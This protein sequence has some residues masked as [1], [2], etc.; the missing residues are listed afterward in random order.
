MLFLAVLV[1][2][3]AVVFA[4]H[5]DGAT[6]ADLRELR[7][8][9]ARLDDRLQLLEDGHPRAREFRQRE[10]A[11]RDRLV[12]LRDEIRLHQQ[13]ED[14]GL[15]ASKGEVADLRRDIRSLSDDI[16]AAYDP[17]PGHARRLD[18][19][20]GTR[21][22]VRLEQG[23]SSRTARVEDRVVA[24]VAESVRHDGHTAIPAGTAVRGTV[25]RAEPAERPSRGGRLEV[26]FDSLVVDG[27]RLDL[28]ARIVQ[29]QE[30]GV[31][32]SKAGLGALIG[33][34]LGAVVDGK[35]GALI[36]AMV[37]GGGTVVASSGD[38]VELPP[39][40]LLTVELER[41]LALTRR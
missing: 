9:V 17:G 13:D 37:G 11:I 28:D 5:P 16:D 7:S 32:K 2:G 3:T 6:P 20:D 25:A 4:D 26:S 18:V 12:V 14:Q 33:G 8:E 36:G 39:G 21:I 15:G 27:Q 38:D 35:R 31:D 34:V 22:T 10:Q 1:A 41:P 30:S 40:T 24:T 23:L 19:P 29:I